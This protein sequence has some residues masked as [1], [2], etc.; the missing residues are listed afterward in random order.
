MNPAL[1]RFSRY[2]SV[3]VSTFLF[4]LG[5]L[6]IAV[7]GFG[8]AYYVATPIAF[9]IAVS[10]NYAVSRSYVFRGTTRVWS[11]G[12]IYFLCVAGIGVIATTTLVAFLVSFLA[13][14]YL[15]ARVLVA[16]IVG[17]A[18]YFFNLYVNFNIAGK[19]Y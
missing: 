1:R 12:Y 18:N 19:H 7:T 4:D 10:I 8:V 11:H 14:H 17:F 5:I 13:L 16:G 6:Y 3:G 15:F 9:L 2:A